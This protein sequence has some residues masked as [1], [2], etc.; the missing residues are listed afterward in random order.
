MAY[1][2]RKGPFIIWIVVQIMKPRQGRRGSANLG[3]LTI[4]IG[5]GVIKHLVTNVNRIIFERRNAVRI[6]IDLRF[7]FVQLT[8][9]DSISRRLGT[10]PLDTFTILLFPLSRPLLVRDT[11]FSL[12]WSPS[13]V[14]MVTPL[15]P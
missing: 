14:V 3:H 13:V 15:Y 6:V 11:V 1:T 4:R 7:Y 5:L 10:S 8:T 2:S 12:S 9:V